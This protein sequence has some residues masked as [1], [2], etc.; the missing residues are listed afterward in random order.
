MDY[1]SE[2]H[3]LSPDLFK[4]MRLKD[5]EDI[6]ASIHVQLNTCSYAVNIREDLLCSK[7]DRSRSQP[8]LL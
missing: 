1:S 6:L 5:R 3:L 2:R 4:S 8:G 7:N